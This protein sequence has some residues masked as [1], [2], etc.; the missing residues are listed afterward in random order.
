MIKNTET[1]INTQIRRQ[2]ASWKYEWDADHPDKE[3]TIFLNPYIYDKKDNKTWTLAPTLDTGANP[4]TLSLE[5][6]DYD[7]T[8][9]NRLDKTWYLNTFKV[10]EDRYLSPGN[11]DFLSI[12][13]EVGNVTIDPFPPS[14]VSDEN[15]DYIILSP[16]YNDSKIVNDSA[17]HIELQF[18]DEAG[19]DFKQFTIKLK[20]RDGQ[21][22]PSGVQGDTQTQPGYLILYDFNRPSENPATYFPSNVPEKDRWI[23]NI[24]IKYDGG[25]LYNLSFDLVSGPECKTEPYSNCRFFATPYELLKIGFDKN[26]NIPTDVLFLNEVPNG[27]STIGEWINYLEQ[28]NR[29]IGNLE[30]E[31]WDLAGN[32]TIYKDENEFW[33]IDCD[34]I[35]KITPV[36]FTFFDE[37]PKNHLVTDSVKGNVWVNAQDLNKFLWRFPVEAKLTSNSIG[38]I[39]LSTYGDIEWQD[40]TKDKGVYNVLTGCRI[41][42]VNNFKEYG[43]VE[44]EAWVETGNKTIDAIIKERTYNIGKYGPFLFEGDGR[45]YNIRRYVPSYLQNTDF[46]DFIEF[47]ELYLNTMYLG[48]NENKNISALEKIA[49]INNFNDIDRIENAL[50]THYEN[51]FGNEIPFDQTSMENLSNI[52]G[53]FGFGTKDQ[54]EIFDTIKYILSNLPNYNK[55]KG[56]NIGIAGL[57]KMFGFCCKLVNLWVKKE[58]RI[59][60]NPTFY[61]E[62]RLH[63]FANLFQTSRFNI[64]VSCINEFKAFNENLDFFID[65]IKTIKPIT[66]ILNKI[67]YSV[68]KSTEVSIVNNVISKELTD[69]VKYTLTWNLDDFRETM[70]ATANV[71]STSMSC[72]YLCLPYK[73]TS[74][75]VDGGMKL[76]NYYTIIGKLFECSNGNLILKCDNNIFEF[77]MYELNVILNPGYF[78]ISSDKGSILTSLY[79]ILTESS[80]IELNIE[81][82]VGTNSIFSI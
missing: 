51:Q 20:I 53:D 61:E 32:K 21:Q 48:M 39:D 35:D 23:K 17:R 25:H 49:R 1:I 80:T 59:E 70:K 12:T 31:I 75:D 27:I 71:D 18:K 78:A 38:Q 45:K 4:N 22:L 82:L 77:P 15:T 54:T 67:K 16:S 74:S 37:Y 79:K 30:I 63:S 40:N 19:L 6:D 42:N 9:K 5:L 52:F 36:T 10:S 68:I 14:F 76:S 41:F 33:T 24:K 62:D 43:F 56:T 46:Y 44:V 47:F 81:Y 26:N 29:A 64:E 73:P 55:Y 69:I 50:L 11:N 57:L 8:P 28:G 60:E 66:K 3:G 7:S 58:D 13:S 34:D 2:D 65:V 72:K